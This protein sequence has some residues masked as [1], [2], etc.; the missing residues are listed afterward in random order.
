MQD[1]N[2]VFHKVFITVPLVKFTVLATV[3]IMMQYNSHQY[4]CS[5]MNEY[6]DWI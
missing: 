2:Y 6:H 3:A 1:V 4:K 5:S